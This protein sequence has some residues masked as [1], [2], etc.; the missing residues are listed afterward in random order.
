[1]SSSRIARCIPI[2]AALVVLTSAAAEKAPGIPTDLR[3]QAERYMQ[4]QSGSVIVYGNGIGIWNDRMQFRVEAEHLRLLLAA[5]DTARFHQMPRGFGSGKQRLVRR[6]SMKSGGTSKE[7][8]QILDGEQSV[9]LKTLTDRFF[10]VLEPLAQ[11]GPA[12]ENLTDGLKKVANGSLA[13]ET[14]RLIVHYKPSPKSVEPGFVFRVEDGI[15]TRQAYKD[16][17]YGDTLTLPETRVRELAETLA[18]ADIETLPA[19]LYASEYSEIH[20][21]V[22]SRRKNVQARSFAGMKHKANDDKQLRFDRLFDRL[23]TL[24]TT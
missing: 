7:V 2:L 9:E 19:N 18:A 6:V 21:E 24:G 10:E 3:L 8:V 11:S 12:A 17:A 22:L 14:L 5:V 16:A 20:V 1:M 15:A 4:G 23:R 13:P